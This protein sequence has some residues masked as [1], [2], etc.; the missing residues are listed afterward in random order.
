[1]DFHV[2]TVLTD[3]FGVWRLRHAWLAACLSG[4]LSIISSAIVARLGGLSQS[5]TVAACL[6]IGVVT[7]LDTLLIL[8]RIETLAH[9][10]ENQ[11]WWLS[12]GAGLRFTLFFGF[13]SWMVGGDVRVSIVGAVVFGAASVFK[14]VAYGS[15]TIGRYTQLMKMPNTRAVPG[16]T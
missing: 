16:N 5:E 13:W 7:F 10:H 12:L 3:R 15:G 1:M 9:W 4:A 11:R 14:T 2:I 6:F 8:A